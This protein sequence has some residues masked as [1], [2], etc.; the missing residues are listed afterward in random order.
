[1]A[2]ED[3]GIDCSAAHRDFDCLAEQ[4]VMGTDIHIMLPQ[5]AAHLDCCANCREEYDALVAILKS[6]TQS[7]IG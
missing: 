2:H 4:A 3:M 6:E 7:N 1:M 5:V